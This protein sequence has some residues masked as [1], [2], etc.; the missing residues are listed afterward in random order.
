MYGV[1]AGPQVAEPA[2]GDCQ[3]ADTRPAKGKSIHVIHR[4]PQVTFRA[5]DHAGADSPAG[6]APAQ[7]MHP[8]VHVMPLSRAAFVRSGLK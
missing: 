3:G 2:A 4:T 5:K 8:C 1:F 6:M 7:S